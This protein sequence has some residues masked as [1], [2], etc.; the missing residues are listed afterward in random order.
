[1]NNS[2]MEQEKHKFI[3]MIL[4]IIC[5]V[6]F[7]AY[8]PS[9]YLSLAEK[10]WII[11]II[12]TLFY[13]YVVA[14]TFIKKIG[15]KIKMLSLTVLAY[16]LGVLLLIFTGPFG[17][18]IIYLFA[19][20]FLVALFYTPK[21]TLWANVLVIVTFIAFGL[22][23][24]LELLPWQQGLASV[25]VILV[26]FVLVAFIL[27]QG[28]SFLMKGLNTYITGQARLQEQLKKE[29]K[30]KQAQTR[31]AEESLATQTHLVTEMHHRVKNNLQ[32]ISSL[33][34]LH[35]SRQSGDDGRLEALKERVAAI[36]RVHWLL[37]TDNRIASMDL[38]RMLNHILDNLFVTLHTG[39]ISFIKRVAVENTQIASDKATLI[40]LVLNEILTNS[41]KHAFPGGRPGEVVVEISQV[42]NPDRKG[43]TIIASDNG[44]GFKP[45][46]WEKKN[47]FGMEILTTLF[48]Q[49]KATYTVE[50]SHGVRYKIHI[51][52]E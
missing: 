11:A 21:I 5:I 33:I 1:M 41:V 42:H 35:L 37:Y 17:A 3:N 22:L 2:A 27:S 31:R 29:I 24:S 9:M 39:N 16:L 38:N 12:D 4:K 18:G 7:I 51:P 8:I 14:V 32:V 30:Q 34:N 48:K 28:I 13:F 49:L 19:F 44:R 25:L 15:M 46:E 36:S 52:L 6:G 20:I 10:V 50:S 40:S 45:A 26:N 47:N 43:I 23:N